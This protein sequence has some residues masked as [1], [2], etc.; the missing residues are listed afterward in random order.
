MGCIIRLIRCCLIENL[1]KKDLDFRRQKWEHKS[2]AEDL[3]TLDNNSDREGKS[4]SNFSISK[5]TKCSLRGVWCIFAALLAVGQKF[6]ASVD[7][8][9]KQFGSLNVQSDEFKD[10]LMDA[11]MEVVGIGVDYGRCGCHHK[12]FGW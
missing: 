8:I 10:S 12:C 11:Q 7:K 2:F 1:S 9:G 6:A 5:Q 4:K 3:K